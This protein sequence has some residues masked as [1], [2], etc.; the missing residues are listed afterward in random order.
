VTTDIASH[1]PGR[2]ACGGQVDAFTARP[3]RLWEPTVP[4][5]DAAGEHGPRLR[6]ATVADA[7]KLTE[8]AQAAYGRYVE[9]LGG[10]P[11]PMTD[12]QVT[13]DQG[14][15]ALPAGTGRMSLVTREDA[16]RAL[17]AAAVSRRVDLLGAPRRRASSSSGVTVTRP[18]VAQVSAGKNHRTPATAG[19]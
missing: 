3:T 12:D 19:Y 8:V 10:P 16:A 13:D 6:P 17:A 9:R 14:T 11:R 18:R 15:L 1:L 4:V 7:P 2:E 5:A